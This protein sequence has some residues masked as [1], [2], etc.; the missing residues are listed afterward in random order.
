MVNPCLF[1]GHVCARKRIQSP[2]VW[3]Y[4]ELALSRNQ[5]PGLPGTGTLYIYIYIYIFLIYTCIHIHI[6]LCVYINLSLQKQAVP[7]NRRLPVVDAALRAVAHEEH[8]VVE[9]G[10]VLCICKN[11]CIYIYICINIYIYIYIYILSLSRKR[12][13]VFFFL[14]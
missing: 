8:A 3:P 7:W 9:P 2:S 1:S 5:S 12:P 10:R 11:M 13:D 14:F 6:H 4:R